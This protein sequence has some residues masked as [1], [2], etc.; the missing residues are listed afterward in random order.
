MSTDGRPTKRQ[1]MS[2]VVLPD[3]D[4]E[5]IST[6]LPLRRQAAANTAANTNGSKG[7]TKATVKSLKQTPSTRSS[8]KSSPEKSRTTKSLSI[9]DTKNKS[10]HTFFT[11][12]SE[13]ERWRKRSATPDE[14]K[15]VE[16]DDDIIDD[17]S[18]DEALAEAI[19]RSKQDVIKEE[20]IPRLKSSAP[21]PPPTK[22]PP[23]SSQRFRKPA[24]PTRSE[25][26]NGHQETEAQAEVKPWADRYSPTSLEELAVHKKKVQDV[27]KWICDTLVGTS[28]QRILVLK[29]PAGTGKSIT[30]QLI[31]QAR[32]CELVAWQNPDTSEAGALSSSLQFAEFVSRGGEYGALSLSND[33]ST[34]SRSF[35]ERIL[36]VEEFPASMTRNSNALESFRSVLRNAAANIGTGT[37][38]GKSLTQ[39][40][41]PPIVLIMSETL[42]S[43]STTFT[44]SFTAQRLL[45]PELMNHPAVN[46]VEFNPVAISFLSK[47]L[48]LVIRKE[49]RESKRRR[50]PGPAVLQKI[51]DMGDLR[52]AINSL[53]FLC[54]RGN[55]NSDWSGTVAANAKRNS[56]SSQPL[57]AMEENSLKLISSRESTLDMFHAA[58][59][60]CYN[61][62]RDPRVLDTRAE[63]PPK[64][65]DHL[66]QSDRPKASEVDI[67][68]LLNETGTDI[69]TFVSTVHQNY[70]LSCNHDDFVDY[71]DEC[72][73]VLSDSE[74]LDPDSKV[75]IRSRSRPQTT[76]INLQMGT[77]DT[78]RQDEISFQVATRGVLFNLPFPVSRATP[79]G[80]GKGSAF[81]MFYPASLR[82]WRPFEE[83]NG[84]IDLVAG[85]LS[86][87][88]SHSLSKDEESRGVATWKTRSNAFET[89]QNSAKPDDKVSMPRTELNKDSLVLEVLPYMTQIRSSRGEDTQLLKKI[90]Q[91]RGFN[92]VIEEEPDDD[93]LLDNAP[94]STS[95]MQ[96]VEAAHQSLQAQRNKPSKK[97]IVDEPAIQNLWIEEDDIEDD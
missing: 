1:R 56:K 83:T 58:G 93:A 40:Q 45:G 9:E 36:L 70:I 17:E 96:K 84:L 10:L 76:G 91:L 5:S 51:T 53:Q 72:A 7:K 66:M 34:D 25:T 68:E 71:F 47:A 95:L 62:R 60:V 6:S 73:K 87:Q 37:V 86:G 4:D 92:A 79:P 26:V 15:R 80:A 43:S 19:R 16:I 42:V 88:Q 74:L 44:D 78:L 3:D 49:A 11:K 14:N 50:I 23:P 69:Q 2:K 12:A 59:K 55:E 63:P 18:A 97:Q 21:L 65:P 29:G 54:T 48:D 8:S 31:A 41:P 67:D 27:Q 81:K 39:A 75:S 28:R 82:L 32:K 85:Q 33:T 20:G 46:V 38:L 90:T 30:V 89:R 77:S 94:T 61:K 52:N 35:P 64:P 13:D 24:I 57:S 22:A